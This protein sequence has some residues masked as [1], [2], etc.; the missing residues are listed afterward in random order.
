MILSDQLA[1][2]SIK[3]RFMCEFICLETRHI[4]GFEGMEVVIYNMIHIILILLIIAVHSR[5]FVL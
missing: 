3:S 2:G 1:E 4:C 5:G